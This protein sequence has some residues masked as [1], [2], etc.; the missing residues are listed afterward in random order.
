MLA[1]KRFQG[2]SGV[3]ILAGCHEQFLVA[4]GGVER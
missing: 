3:A 2:P 1:L 4:L